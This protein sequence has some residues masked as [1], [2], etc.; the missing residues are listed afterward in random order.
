MI[1]TTQIFRYLARTFPFV[2]ATSHRA[3]P[4]RYDILASVP[5]TLVLSFPNNV[6]THEHG[7]FGYLL[8][9]KKR[10]DSW[11]LTDPNRILGTTYTLVNTF[12]ITMLGPTR[13]DQH[14]I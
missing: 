9:G 14:F 6:A 11:A 7:V 13:P 3:I 1:C 8:H 10:K 4:L 5:P 2:I 12:D